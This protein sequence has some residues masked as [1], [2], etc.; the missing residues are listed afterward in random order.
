MPHISRLLLILRSDQRGAAMLD[1]VSAAALI[2]G[3]MMLASALFG[4]PVRRYYD[5]LVAAI[6]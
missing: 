1:F 2:G 5:S 4:V 3:A 6:S